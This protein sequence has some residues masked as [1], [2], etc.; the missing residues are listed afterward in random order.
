MSLSLSHPLRACSP[1]RLLLLALAGLAFAVA[2]GAEAQQAHALCAT[3]PERGVWRNADPASG[4]IAQ[5]ELRD[6]QSLTTCSGSI[7][8]TQFDVAWKTRV[9]GKCSPANCDWGW[10]PAAK[11]LS[12]GQVYGA[13][14]QGYA[15][16]YVYAAMSSYRPGQ[17]WVYWRTDFTDPSRADYEKHEWFVK[18]AS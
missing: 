13:F 5:I 15:K 7:C 10:S 14:N 17:L 9:W 12:S 2:A 3:P 16:R 1:R 4:G 6:C 11:R 8:Q 18:V